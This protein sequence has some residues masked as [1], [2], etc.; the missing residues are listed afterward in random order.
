MRFALLNMKLQ[1]QNKD[2]DSM[3]IFTVN[4]QHI[5]A[6]DIVFERY[7]KYDCLIGINSRQLHMAKKVSSF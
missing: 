1:I 3:K 2:V 7:E 4:I 5:L 6:I